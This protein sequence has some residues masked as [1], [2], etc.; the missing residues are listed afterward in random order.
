MHTMFAT[1]KAHLD[2]WLE[3]DEPDV[4]SLSKLNP[5]AAQI[6][7]AVFTKGD[8]AQAA[9]ELRNAWRAPWYQLRLSRVIVRHESEWTNPGKWKQL[10]EWIEQRT[11]HDPTHDEELKRISK[12][13]WWN[14]V[15]EK[16]DGFPSSSDV[17]H[18]HPIVLVGNFL[19]SAAALT[20]SEQGLW[21]IF[22][23]EAQADVSNHLHWPG[24][25]S[26][27]TLGP[28]DRRDLEVRLY[29]NGEYKWMG[30]HC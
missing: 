23:R 17:F 25:S 14:E 26:G 12:L 1:P 27:V 28:V 13:V 2:Y 3:A 24:G 6:Y 15:A 21:F 5:L 9:D 10:E 22:R 4:P 29:K 11:A 8:G 20:I 19:V 30:T 18:I 7:R 16:I